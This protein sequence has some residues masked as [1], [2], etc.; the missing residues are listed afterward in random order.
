MYQ[1]ATLSE[2][3]ILKQFDTSLSEGLS[4]RQAEERLAAAGYNA[5]T[6]NQAAMLI[7]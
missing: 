7:G 1:H 4:S 3:E 5:I 2:E 6:A